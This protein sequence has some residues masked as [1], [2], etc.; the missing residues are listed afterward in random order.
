MPVC[1]LAPNIVLLHNRPHSLCGNPFCEVKKSEILVKRIRTMDRTFTIND[2]LC[3]CAGSDGG[4]EVALKFWDR[5]TGSAGQSMGPRY[6]LNTQVDD[7]HRGTVTCVAHHPIDDVAVSTGSEGD[8]RV[9]ARQAG[10]RRSRGDPAAASSRHWQCRSV[11]SYRGEHILV[12]LPVQ[13]D[14]Q[15]V[16]HTSFVIRRGDM[17][18]V[19]YLFVGSC[20]TCMA[21]CG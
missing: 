19:C 8:F 10:P 4:A 9:W 5:A 2:R 20:R 18:C 15:P 13:D 3:C 6:V 12:S 17:C 7:P 14:T 1:L 16:P 11:A 21:R